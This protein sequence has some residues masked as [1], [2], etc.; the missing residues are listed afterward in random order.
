ML[1]GMCGLAGSGKDTCADHLVSRHRFTK[2]ALADPLK[3]AAA[4]WFG[5]SQ[6]TLWGPSSARNQP[7]ERYGGLTPRKALQVMGTEMG[8][9]L[10][11]DLWIEIALQTAEELST[12]RY[13]YDPQFGIRDD[14]PARQLRRDVVI[15]DVRFRNEVK[16]IQEAG[17]YVILL[18]RGMRDRPPWWKWWDRPHVSERELLSIPESTF[19]FVLDNRE[20]SVHETKAC[21]DVF[22]AAAR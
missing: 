11:P 9:T 14:V 12:G 3:R 18:K 15:T 7:D 16:A 2:I 19:D 5:W 17:G 13:G 6:H 8:R 1:I 4:M 22:M 21:L 10:Y 20:R